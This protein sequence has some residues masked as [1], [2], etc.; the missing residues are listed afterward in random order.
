ML[1]LK[2]THRF[3]KDFIKAIKSGKDI[4]K[5]K[6]VMRK[7]AA[8]ESLEKKHKDHKLKG[9][10]SGRR[11]CHVEPDW[12]LIYKIEGDTIIFERTGTHSELFG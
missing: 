12:L 2:T 9:G 10:F 7:L 6:I 1:K 11:E 5:I 4:E 3:D 8:Q